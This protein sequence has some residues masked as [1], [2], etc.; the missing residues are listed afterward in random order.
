MDSKEGLFCSFDYTVIFVYLY[1]LSWLKRKFKKMGLK[2]KLG[3]APD[4]SILIN[5]I[6]VN[7]CIQI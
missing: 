3:D 6:E 5:M 4:E 1:S 2:R 7:A